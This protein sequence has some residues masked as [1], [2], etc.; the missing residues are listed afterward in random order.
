MLLV[1]SLNIRPV[2]VSANG[3]EEQGIKD[4]INTYFALRYAEV[5]TL[6]SSDFSGILDESDTVTA[7][8]QKTEKNRS[9]IKKTIAT[10]FGE[11]ILDAKFSLNYLSI[12][13]SDK[14]ATVTLLESNVIVYS[15][16]PTDPSKMAD[17]PHEITLKIKDGK[18][19][20][21][22][23]KYED[24]LTYVLSHSSMEEAFN[25][26]KINHEILIKK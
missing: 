12:N 9:E 8:W 13:I 26:I 1:V 21:Q 2:N 6:N 4:T 22:K 7:D 3:L 23:D 15:S 11:N 5:K 24:E 17:L 16:D 20:I 18:W 25:N 19:V 10:T 14:K